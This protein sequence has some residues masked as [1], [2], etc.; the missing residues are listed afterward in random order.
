MKG[1]GSL[2]AR[3][4]IYWLT[5]TDE[6]GRIV[7][8][9]SGSRDWNVAER[10]LAQAVYPILADRLNQIWDIAYGE[11]KTPGNGHGHR[12]AETARA[13]QTGRSPRGLAGGVEPVDRNRR[14]NP[15]RPVKEGK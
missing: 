7:Q 10:L 13:G 12:A 4:G 3:E 9:S 15:A 11:E 1:A 2:S 8:R 6:E 14:A 5:Y